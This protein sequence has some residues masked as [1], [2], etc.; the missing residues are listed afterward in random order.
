MNELLVIKYNGNETCRGWHLGGTV[1]ATT[2]VLTMK[3][4]VTH[5]A[6][7]TSLLLVTFP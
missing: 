4:P 1:L 7:R 6:L 5:P 3:M 2:K